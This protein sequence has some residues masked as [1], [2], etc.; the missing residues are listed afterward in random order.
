MRTEEHDRDLQGWQADLHL[1]L[2]EGVIQWRHEALGRDDHRA[3][4]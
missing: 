3:V 4:R 1:L 2:N